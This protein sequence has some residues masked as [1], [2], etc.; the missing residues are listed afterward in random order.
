ME[1]YFAQVILAEKPSSIP[2]AYLLLFI[3]YPKYA[4]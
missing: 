4:K 1:E 3:V 2:L